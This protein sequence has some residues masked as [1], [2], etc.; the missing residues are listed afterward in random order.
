MPDLLLKMKIL[1]SEY[2]QNILPE[3]EWDI[4]RKIQ[5]LKDT[6]DESTPPVE[7]IAEIAAFQFV[8]DYNNQDTG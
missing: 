7:W 3:F 8:E 1:L 5:S 6:N 4:S 2:D